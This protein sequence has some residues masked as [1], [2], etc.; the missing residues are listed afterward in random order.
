MLSPL[1]HA[2]FSPLRY[3]IAAF[4]TAILCKIAEY[5]SGC[6]PPDA[7]ENKHRKK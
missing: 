7:D 2:G 5:M 1:W 4:I 3:Q 6:P